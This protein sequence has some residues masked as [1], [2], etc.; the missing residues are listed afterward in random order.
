MSLHLPLQFLGG[1]LSYSAARIRDDALDVTAPQLTGV[2]FDDDRFIAA[3]QD[4]AGLVLDEATLNIKTKLLGVRSTLMIVS[5]YYG[6]L[7]VT[8][9]LTSRRICWF[10][11]IAFFLDMV[12]E[13]LVGWHDGP[14]LSVVPLGGGP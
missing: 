10:T 2:P 12:Q 3:H 5:C 9:D 14:Y 7:T 1:G 6:E 8:G 13:L 11:S 4:L